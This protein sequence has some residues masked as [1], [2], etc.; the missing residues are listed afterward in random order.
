MNKAIHR[1]LDL[2]AHLDVS[3]RQFD[4]SIGTANGYTLR[5]H[6]NNASVGSDV[7]ERIVKTYPQIN[8]VWL[9][10]GKGE[11]FIKSTKPKTIDNVNIESFINEQLNK[12]WSEEKKELLDEIMKEINLQLK[13]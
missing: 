2:I 1:I 6:K 5:M 8:L 7:I 11:M 3:A 9:I 10:T 13:K 12:K 4:L